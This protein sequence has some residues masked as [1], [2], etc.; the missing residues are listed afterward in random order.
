MIENLSEKYDH[1]VRQH[2]DKL[3]SSLYVKL[4]FQKVIICN[5]FIYSSTGKSF[6]NVY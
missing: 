2:K 3:E 4:D 5:I 1:V 6:N